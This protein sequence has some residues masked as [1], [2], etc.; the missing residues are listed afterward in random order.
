[1]RRRKQLEMACSLPML[2]LVLLA[3]SLHEM[4]ALAFPLPFVHFSPPLLVFTGTFGAYGLLLFG[5]FHY[6]RTG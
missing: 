5:L 1:M 6:G 3:T 2:V 4:G